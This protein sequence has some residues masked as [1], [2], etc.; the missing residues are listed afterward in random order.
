MMSPLLGPG[1][2]WTTEETRMYPVDKVPSEL[3]RLNTSVVSF[4]AIRTRFSRP[5]FAEIDTR[6]LA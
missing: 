2:Q 1:N 3:A 6:I 4:G 5:F